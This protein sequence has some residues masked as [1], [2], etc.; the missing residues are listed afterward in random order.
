MKSC[1]IF[2]Y[3][4]LNKL[5]YKNHIYSNSK[6]VSFDFYSLDLASNHQSEP[7]TTTSILKQQSET[8]IHAVQPKQQPKQQ[9]TS[10]ITTI[11]SNFDYIQP[12]T[13]YTSHS[14]ST[15]SK[16]IGKLLKKISMLIIILIN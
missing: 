13:N 11:Q 5:I 12:N 3:F 16:P 2:M 14:S 6:S 10:T 7:H 4:K 1:N 8:P 9:L 15:K